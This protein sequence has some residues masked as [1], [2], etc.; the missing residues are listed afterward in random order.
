MTG[1]TVNTKVNVRAAYYKQARAMCHRLFRTGSYFRPTPASIDPNAATGSSKEPELIETLNPL[2]GILSYIYHVKNSIDQRD[3]ITKQENETAA[4]KLYARFLF[5]RYFVRLDRPLIICEGKTDNVYLKYA[6]R[7]M[8][9][10]HPKLGKFSDQIFESTLAF[11]N[12]GNQAR[13]LLKIKG[14][15]GDQNTC[16]FVIRKTFRL[17]LINL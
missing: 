17:Y 5:Y 12:H 6:I 1:L 15:T 10:F 13:E 2:E 4:R 14:G 9:A 7:Q 11:F 16:S 8:P 3:Y